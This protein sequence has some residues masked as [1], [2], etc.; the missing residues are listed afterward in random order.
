[1]R[2]PVC[3]AAR[4]YTPRTPVK[5]TQLAH[6]SSLAG[7]S[8]LP[9]FWAKMKG[10]LSDSRRSRRTE[11]RVPNDALSRSTTATHWRHGTGINR[12]EL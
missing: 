12:A 5:Y 7:S 2:D 9:F 11:R 8:Y 3:W 6:D 10:Y 4:I 1:M